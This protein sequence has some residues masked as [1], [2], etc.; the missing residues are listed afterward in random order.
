M[1]IGS[2]NVLNPVELVLKHV[3]HRGAL[4]VQCSMR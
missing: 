3:I 1:L 4:G 2:E